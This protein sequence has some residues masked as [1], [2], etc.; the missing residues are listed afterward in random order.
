MQNR[1]LVNWASWRRSDED[2]IAGTRADRWRVT[3]YLETI[4]GSTRQAVSKQLLGVYKPV[5]WAK[6]GLARSGST[7]QGGKTGGQK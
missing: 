2:A 3:G 6:S 5:G 1:L 4:G 7:L